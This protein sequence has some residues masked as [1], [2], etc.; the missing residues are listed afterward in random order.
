M[1]IFLV[2]FYIMENILRIYI[3]RNNNDDEDIPYQKR[4][5][6]IEVEME[7]KWNQNE[8]D[9]DAAQSNYMVNDFIL[10]ISLN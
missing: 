8:R 2:G 1:K 7:R 3:C 9:I 10:T 5:E 6:E 4:R